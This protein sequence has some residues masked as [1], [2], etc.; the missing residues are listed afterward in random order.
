MLFTPGFEDVFTPKVWTTKWNHQCLWFHLQPDLAALSQAAGLGVPFPMA[1]EPGEFP[2]FGQVNFPSKNQVGVA[3]LVAV[4]SISYPLSKV[5]VLI[6][7]PVWSLRIGDILMASF[8]FKKRYSFQAT[9]Q[10][11][12]GA[13]MPWD[14]VERHPGVGVF[15]WVFVELLKGGER[16]GR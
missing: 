1:R 11:K 15:G 6:Q 2:K 12:S 13:V 5:S 3:K 16:S 14:A 4:S 10:L 8:C 7:K 9:L